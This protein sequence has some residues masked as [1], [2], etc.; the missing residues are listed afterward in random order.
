MQVLIG[1]RQARQGSGS[2]P[3]NPALNPQAV[4]GTNIY[5]SSHAVPAETVIAAGVTTGANFTGAKVGTLLAN[6]MPA[7]GGPRPASVAGVV[8]P[9]SQHAEVPAVAEGGLFESQLKHFIQN[10]SNTMQAVLPLK[11]I[12]GLG[13]QPPSN[14]IRE[15]IS[16]SGI[17]PPLSLMQPSNPITSCTSRHLISNP[18]LVQPQATT[19]PQPV[20]HA[21]ST[22]HPQP[23]TTQALLKWQSEVLCPN[24][25]SASAVKAFDKLR[26]SHE[27]PHLPPQ[28]VNLSKSI[29]LKQQLEM[30]MQYYQQQM[31]WAQKQLQLMQ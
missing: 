25:T 1:A 9:L 21:Q 12:G 20:V 13:L 3:D 4:N 5:D 2:Q 24:T 14:S 18:A 19:Q 27:V 23:V 17:I 26:C 6:A 22:I 15:D 7:N 8:V 31:F 30:Q 29:E 16:Y 11:T 28:E 10:A